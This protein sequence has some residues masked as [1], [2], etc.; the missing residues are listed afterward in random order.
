M[1]DISHTEFRKKRVKRLKRII[2][3]AFFI[4]LT[5]PLALA[6]WLAC[7]LKAREN[8]LAEIT[9]QYEAQLSITDE[10]QERLDEETA[11]ADGLR[12]EVDEVTNR[13]AEISEEKIA[14]SEPEEETE[15]VD[16]GIRRVYLT[17][18]DGPSIYTEQILDILDKYGVKATFFVTGEEADTNPERYRAIVDRGHSIGMHSFT[19][20]YS[21]VYK[22]KGNFIRDYQKIR[23]YITETTGV[24]P[25]IYRFPG[26][27]SNTVSATD[28]DELCQWLTDQDVVYFDWNISSGDATRYALSPGRITSN[29]LKNV[30]NFNTAVILMH[31]VS[32]KYTTVQALPAIIEGIQALE[33]TQ[34]LPITED[35]VPV[36]HRQVQTDTDTE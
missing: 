26:G 17:F 34:I 28:M 10:L 5:I 31:D 2:V 13:L 11:L 32:T 19:H 1:S 33:D 14:Y 29:C 4:F 20:K 16:D 23:N 24:T 36:Q 27:S 8:E 7:E 21:E 15:P 30:E 18:D 3:A 22:N 25:T 12:A 6:I 9:S 35:T